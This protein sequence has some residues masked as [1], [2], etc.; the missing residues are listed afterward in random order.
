MKSKYMTI[1]ASYGWSNEDI[2]KQTLKNSVEG[3]EKELHQVKGELIKLEKIQK[4]SNEECLQLKINNSTLLKSK[5]N[6]EEKYFTLLTFKS[7]GYCYLLECL[8]LE[9]IFH[10]ISFLSGPDKKIFRVCCK[11]I[12]N[13]CQKPSS[14]PPPE[15]FSEPPSELS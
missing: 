4:K 2:E 5:L 3:L 10:I 7:V 15:L 1:G 8:P 6:L 9:L 11:P 13:I 12:Y 14:E